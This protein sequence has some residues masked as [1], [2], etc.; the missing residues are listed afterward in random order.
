[1]QINMHTH[2][3]V[4]DV[5]GCYCLIPCT[6]LHSCDTQI[7]LLGI[8][9]AVKTHLTLGGI[10]ENPCAKQSKCKGNKRVGVEMKR[11][12]RREGKSFWMPFRI[13]WL[14]RD[15]M[16]ILQRNKPDLVQVEAWFFWVARWGSRS[17]AQQRE[18]P[19]QSQLQQA[20]CN[21]WKKTFKKMSTI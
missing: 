6:C 17:A 10:L 21:T 18:R 3:W 19:S 14:D 7:W 12:T 9:R 11:S 15:G 4:I 1:M 8:S 2:L 13:R 5:L 20:Y 16:G